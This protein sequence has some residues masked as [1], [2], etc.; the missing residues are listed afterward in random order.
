MEFV[1]KI[2]GKQHLAYIRKEI[3]EAFGLRLKFQPN[4]K[5][6]I[7]YSEGVKASDVIKSV[8]ILLADLRLRA[9]DES[10]GA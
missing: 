7:V 2:D 9:E 3:V 8:E 1:I 4:S 5:A 6:A 10:K